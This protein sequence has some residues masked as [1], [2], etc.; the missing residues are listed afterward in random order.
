MRDVRFT[1]ALDCA[2]EVRA[3]RVSGG[4]TATRLRGYGRAGLP[5][6]VSLRDRKLGAGQIRLSLT[7]T[8]PVNAGVP[9]T[10]ES[11]ALTLR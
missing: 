3:I 1:C 6:V 9:V 10:R 8:H 11:R 2:W 5:L 7:L 4:A